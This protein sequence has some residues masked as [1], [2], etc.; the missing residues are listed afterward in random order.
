MLRHNNQCHKFRRRD[1]W[2]LVAIQLQKP[3]SLLLCLELH[4]TALN[5]R[6]TVLVFLGGGDVNVDRCKAST[7]QVVLQVWLL[8]VVMHAA[9]KYLSVVV[10]LLLH[11][12]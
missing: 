7:L 3:R 1:P 5:S 10:P 11:L 9:K 6:I 4:K 12:A 2:V 8:Q